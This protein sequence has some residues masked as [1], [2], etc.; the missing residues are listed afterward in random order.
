MDSTPAGVR[1][2]IFSLSKLK[3]N[4]RAILVVMIYVRGIT[5]SLNYTL[6]HMSAGLRKLNIQL[7]VVG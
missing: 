1:Q 5:G 4:W 2:E 7:N 3:N 6:L